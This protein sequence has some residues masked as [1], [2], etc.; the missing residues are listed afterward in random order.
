MQTHWCFIGVGMT[1][2][3]TLMEVG[4][5]YS[6]AMSIGTVSSLASNTVHFCVSIMLSALS[7]LP[8]RADLMLRLHY[9]PGGY[10]T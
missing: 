6:A 2:V 7:H 5:T 8:L 1:T 10:M 9:D 3:Q 4:Y